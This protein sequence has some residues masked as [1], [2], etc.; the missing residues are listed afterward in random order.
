MRRYRSYK[1]TAK[2][3]SKGGIRSSIAGAA[4]LLCTAGS[5]Y[6]AYLAKG[7][8]ANYLAALGFV[9]MILSIYGTFTGYSSFK[10]EE[11]YYLFSRIGTCT[12]FVL[13]IFWMA[14]FGMGFIM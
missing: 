7:D 3:H 13:M 11:S 1:F 6:G 4:A 2:R 14:I 12:N 10:E 5:V 8:G 9:A